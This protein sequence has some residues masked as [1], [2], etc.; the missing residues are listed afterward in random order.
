MRP[1]QLLAM[2]FSFETLQS[3]QSSRGTVPAGFRPT[4]D[5]AAEWMRPVQLLASLFLF[6]TLQSLQS[7]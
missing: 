6:E 5:G 4:C 3:L 1:V 2:L 7:F